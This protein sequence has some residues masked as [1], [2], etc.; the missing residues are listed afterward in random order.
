MNQYDC[1]Y[2]TEGAGGYA[3][4]WLYVGIGSWIHMV[5]MLLLSS[6]DFPHCSLMN[7]IHYCPIKI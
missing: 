2:I 1:I 7:G 3:R 4:E 5:N 6:I